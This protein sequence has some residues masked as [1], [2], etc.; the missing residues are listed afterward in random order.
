MAALGT[1]YWGYRG[2][3][4]STGVSMVGVLGTR[5][6]T[7]EQYGGSIKGSLGGTGVSP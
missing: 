1:V 5:G 4:G 7:G 6:G 2:M 3:H